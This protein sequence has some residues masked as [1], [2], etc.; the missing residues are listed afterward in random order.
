MYQATIS[1]NEALILI[2]QGA[3]L[4]DVRQPHEYARGALPGSVNIP[5]PDIQRAL[6]QL[7]KDTPVLLYCSSGQLSGTARCLL[8]ACGFH[9]VHNL[10]SR[11]DFITSEHNKQA[12]Q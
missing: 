8:K 7:D 3:Q 11:S 4:V 6:K 12:G 2:K 9:Q 5:L 1:Q 10:G